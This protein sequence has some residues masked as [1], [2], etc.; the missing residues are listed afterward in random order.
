MPTFSNK[1]V[2]LSNYIRLWTKKSIGCPFFRFYTKNHCCHSNVMSKKRPFSENNLLSCPY[3]V[4]KRIFF[5]KLRS[6]LIIF[7]YFSWKTPYCQAHIWS[8]TREFCQ[9]YTILWAKKINR[10]PYALMRIFPKNVHSLRNTMLS[11]VYYFKKRSIL[12]KAT[13]SHVI[14]F[15]IYH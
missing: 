12:P 1:S 10:M 2:N 5:S 6:S 14:C 9:N 11:C 8:K 7:F 15:K 3:V 4:K 13:W